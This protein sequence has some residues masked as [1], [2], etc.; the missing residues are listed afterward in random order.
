[1]Y[2]GCQGIGT[3]KKELQFLTRHGVNNMDTQIDPDDLDQIVK[4]RE[5]AEAE[6]VSLEMIHIL[7]HAWSFEK[8]ASAPH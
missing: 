2:V 8:P 6:G 1:M 4:Q 5:E 7:Q 3:S